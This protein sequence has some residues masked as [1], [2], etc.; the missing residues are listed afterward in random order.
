MRDVV[1]MGVQLVMEPLLERLLENAYHVRAIR[2]GHEFKRTSDFVD[3]YVLT[4]DCVLVEVN[5]VR[6]NKHRN[7]RAVHS[8]LFVPILQI[9][10]S[11]L[12]VYVENHHTHM[13]TKVVRA[14]Q[15]VE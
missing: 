15:L 4:L 1:L 7:V 5:L 14:V 12:A 9:L 3:K 6:Y 11:N 10:V 8:Q 2:G 13:R